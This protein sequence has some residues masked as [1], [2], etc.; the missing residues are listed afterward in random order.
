MGQ[1]ATDDIK[2]TIFEK[3]VF[4]LVHFPKRSELTMALM[5]ARGE[6]DKAKKAKGKGTLPNNVMTHKAL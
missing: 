6:M 2:Q 1:T 4:L 5:Q 3:Q